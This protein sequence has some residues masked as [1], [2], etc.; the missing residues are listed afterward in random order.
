MALAGI[1]LACLVVVFAWWLEQRPEP[2]EPTRPATQEMI[3]DR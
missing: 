1:V 2:V 3:E